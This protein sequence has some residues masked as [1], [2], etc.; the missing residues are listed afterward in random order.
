MQ[1]FCKSIKKISSLRKTLLT[2][3]QAYSC[4]RFLPPHTQR[5]G[6]SALRRT[7]LFDIYIQGIYLCWWAYADCNHNTANTLKKNKSLCSQFIT[8]LRG[9]E[10]LCRRFSIITGSCCICWKLDCYWFLFK[11][12]G[13]S[14]NR[15]GI[16]MLVVQPQRSERER[17]RDCVSNKRRMSN[18]A[19][20]RHK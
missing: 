10:K 3:R 7:V 15:G 4:L 5:G 9:M 20:E 12:S 14:A 11:A 16:K 6:V 8:Q 1:E 17:E 19:C 18:C 2:F 13:F